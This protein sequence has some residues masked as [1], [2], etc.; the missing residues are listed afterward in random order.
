[1]DYKDLDFKIGS[2]NPS[3]IGETIYAIRKRFI[4]SWPKVIDDPDSAEATDSDALV[5]L[6]GDFV[7]KQGKTFI[8]IYS[9]QGKGSIASEALGETDCK[10]FKNKL[11]AS[12]PDLSPAA[13]GFQ[14]LTVNDDYVFIAKAAGRYHVIGSPD[15]RSVTSINASS[16]DAAGSAKGLTIAVECPDVTPTPIYSGKIA[17]A[18]G[19][20]DCATGVF[21]AAGKPAGT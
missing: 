19:S 7:L 13:V 5:T 20:F 3:G 11:N 1:M 6:T 9:T 10:M 8:R 12:F 17:L 16:G 4:E 14:K 18:D 2:V 15:Y 21:T